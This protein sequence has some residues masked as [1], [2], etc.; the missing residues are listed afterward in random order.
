MLV[1]QAALHFSIA[2]MFRQPVAASVYLYRRKHALQT[3]A[4]LARKTYDKKAAH[5]G[6]HQIMKA[7]RSRTRPR[8]E[9]YHRAVKITIFYVW[10][11]ILFFTMHAEVSSGSPWCAHWCTVTTVSRLAG[12]DTI[13]LFPTY[14]SPRSTCRFEHSKP[15]IAEA[16]SR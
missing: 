13:T 15:I 14:T 2:S 3:S 16:T 6:P 9:S 11:Q 12:A 7:Q 8:F 10:N 4:V 5:I 1:L